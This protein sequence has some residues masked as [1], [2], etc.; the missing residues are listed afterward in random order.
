M[1][2]N[3]DKL[4][5][6]RLRAEPA[7]LTCK[8]VEAQIG[9]TK[10]A[11]VDCPGFNDTYRSSTEILEEI[12]RILCAQSALGRHLRLKGVIY[13][14]SLEKSKMEHGDMYALRI[15]R[16]L[17]GEEALPHVALVTTKWGN[18]SRAE[19][20]TA[21]EREAELIDK[22]WR[23]M[24]D[25][26]AQVNRFDGDTAS[27]QGIV[28]QLI[29]KEEVTLALQ[30]ELIA[31]E[32]KLK[33]T[34]AGASLASSMERDAA[35]IRRELQELSARIQAEKNKTKRIVAEKNHKIV[36]AK[37]D[38][39]VADKAQMEAK[40]GVR[41]RDTIAKHRRDE[42]YKWGGKE[43]KL[44][45]KVLGFGL[46]TILPLVVTPCSIM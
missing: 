14:H 21:L 44:F 26:G 41:M 16:E 6:Y 27:A 12:A 33:E 11:V 1:D 7:T 42:R 23:A 43:L 13:L 34:F 22:F 24:M 8:V 18:F 32:K 2:A 5:L 19:S 40:V 25:K 46:T 31:E 36:E 29:E 35:D 37:N 28:S 15:F 17:V 30:H 39:I 4:K 10:V 45:C 9:N 38:R 20:P 3:T